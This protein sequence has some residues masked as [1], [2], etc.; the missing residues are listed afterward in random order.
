M[1]PERSVI[2]GHQTPRPFPSRAGPCKDHRAGYPACPRIRSGGRKITPPVIESCRR[3]VRLP[4]QAKIENQLAVYFPVILRKSGKI[5][6]LLANE[7]G[8]VNG[9]GIRI[10]QQER[11][12][13]ITALV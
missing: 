2:A 1:R 13:S 11:G 3:K 9:P 4:T 8:G 6:E 7:P 12:K 5:I 10:P